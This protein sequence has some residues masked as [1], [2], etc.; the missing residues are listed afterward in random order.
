VSAAA[1]RGVAA[2]RGE[3][4]RVVRRW[5]AVTPRL[6]SAIVI[7]AA[8]LATSALAAA[9]TAAERPVPLTVATQ[10]V[11]SAPDHRHPHA[12]LGGG[13][14]LGLVDGPGADR[15]WVARLEYELFPALTPPGKLGGFFGFLP[16]FQAWRTERGWGL[17]VPVAFTLGVRAPGVRFGVIAGVEALLVDTVDG[18]TGVGLYAPLAGLRLATEVRGWYAAADVRVTRRW[19][20]GA[21]DFTQ[22]QAAFAIGH[23]WETRPS[24]P[25]R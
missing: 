12:G 3:S 16:G 5:I 9:Q 15:G 20:F 4:W 2:P 21:D 18:D 14:S 25:V 10:P 1:A 6:L 7:G 24:T 22:W 17:G 19:Q 13:L 11:A 8:L 23:T